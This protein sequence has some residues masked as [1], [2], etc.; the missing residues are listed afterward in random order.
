MEYNLII[1]EFKERQKEN[2]YRDLRNA[3]YTGCFAQVEKPKELYDKIVNSIEARPQTGEEIFQF[4]KSM[5]SRSGNPPREILNSH[6][7][8]PLKLTPDFNAGVFS[9][10]Y[11]IEEETFTLYLPDIVLSLD[12]TVLKP[13]NGM[14]TLTPGLVK[15]KYGEQVYSIIITRN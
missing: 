11:R 14:Y 4:L 6:F 1:E 5:A 15:I 9:Y 8:I 10:I 13:E 2:L 12:G 7:I 3:Y